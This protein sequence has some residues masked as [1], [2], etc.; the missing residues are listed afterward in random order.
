M[1]NSTNTSVSLSA[2]ISFNETSLADAHA[3]CSNGN[4][5]YFNVNISN[6]TEANANK[7]AFIADVTNFLNQVF[8]T[9]IDVKN[10]D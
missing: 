3:S 6:F 2:N 9:V 8:E 7:E 5:V 1:L 4:E 10:L